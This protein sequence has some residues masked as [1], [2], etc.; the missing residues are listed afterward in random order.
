[1]FQDPNQLTK[2]GKSKVLPTFHSLD[3]S[4]DSDS[5]PSSTSSDLQVTTERGAETGDGL[6]Q[7][8]AAI[9][10]PRSNVSRKK[11]AHQKR[12]FEQYLQHLQ[13]EA[14]LRAIKPSSSETTLV[15]RYLNMLGSDLTGK[16]PFYI[17]GTWIQSIPSR[18]GSNR[19]LD[20][21]VEFFVNSYAVYCDDTHSKR[22]LAR[23]SK[24][25][26]LRELQLFVMDA[27][28]KPTYEVLLATKMH[29]A[30]EVRTNP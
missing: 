24:T 10:K 12:A 7:T 21:A 3:W 25:T 26:A 4:G 1:M 17:L 28:S 16:Q 29:Y 18:I 2:H 6:F 8:L 13:R 27:H 5:T 9:S 15:F 19:M 23:I 30:A 14:A 20:L 11:L 22:E